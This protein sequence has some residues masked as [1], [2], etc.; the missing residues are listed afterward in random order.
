MHG[1]R[2]RTS[3]I[4]IKKR[5]LLII[6]KIN[7]PSRRSRRAMLSNP[8]RLT[9][10][11]QTTIHR[12]VVLTCNLCQ[13]DQEP[14]GLLREDNLISRKKKRWQTD[15]VMSLLP[16]KRSLQIA[17][18][19]MLTKVPIFPNSSISSP[20]QPHL[21]STRLGS[22]LENSSQVAISRP[23]LLMVALTVL[24]AKMLMASSWEVFR[25]S[26][27]LRT[28]AGL[29]M[30]LMTTM[31][32]AIQSRSEKFKPRTRNREL[33]ARAIAQLSLTLIWVTVILK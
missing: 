19:L 16:S 13:V 5:E 12:L 9:L 23:I 25:E 15:G 24:R 10:D 11:R 21:T 33:P 22:S 29:P 14:R 3:L 30:T 6:R 1:L 31:V 28:T 26:R 4:M 27:I 17:M 8:P 2:L 7:T 20:T 18:A 32:L